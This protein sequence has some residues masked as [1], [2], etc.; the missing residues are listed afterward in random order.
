MPQSD[1]NGGGGHWGDNES[2]PFSPKQSW[3]LATSTSDSSFIF[4]LDTEPPTHNTGVS[5]VDHSGTARHGNAFR[6]ASQQ[7]IFDFHQVQPLPAVPVSE[8]SRAS[9]GSSQLNIGGDWRSSFDSTDSALGNINTGR[10]T[11]GRS[12][13]GQTARHN[14]T[15]PSSQFSPTT[16]IASRSS[17]SCTDAEAPRSAPR[18]YV[19]NQSAPRPSKASSMNSRF[20][21]TPGTGQ[22]ASNRKS[23]PGASQFNTM[24][25][26][27][28]GTRT[29]EVDE[30][31]RRGQ[32][33]QSTRGVSLVSSTSGLSSGEIE[34]PKYEVAN[35]DNSRQ[36]LIQENKGAGRTPGVLRSG[37]DNVTQNG[38]F[39]LPPGKGF[40]IQIGS[41]LFRLSGASIMSDG[42]YLFQRIT[43]E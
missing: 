28:T 42:Q 20:V 12:E 13:G 17:L 31:L 19:V 22:V 16:S 39:T 24:K 30:D 14:Q 9:A 34:L 25:K 37:Q 40:P 27:Y 11:S 7:F 3:L 1:S 35:G 41:E 5:V 2:S 8:Q 4:A 26:M 21:K 23:P 10:D 33:G 15:A 29:L 43:G 38:Q 18:E 32:A 6:D 36:S